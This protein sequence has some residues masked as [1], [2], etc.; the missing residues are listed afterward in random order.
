MIIESNSV[1]ERGNHQ[2]KKT[3]TFT[4]L[5]KGCRKMDAKKAHPILK[6]KLRFIP[7]FQTGT[8]TY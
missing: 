4:G 6:I 5:S 7:M 2:V 1:I 8:Y 3:A